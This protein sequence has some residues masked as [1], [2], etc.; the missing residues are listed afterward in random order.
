[1]KRRPLPSL[2]ALRVFE[3]FAHFQN[4]TKAAEEL[5]ISPSAISRHLKILSDQVGTALVKPDGRNLRLTVPG[6]E[7]ASAVGGALDQV[8]DAVEAMRSDPNS[9]TVRA[10]PTFA[11]RW[12]YPRLTRFNSEYPAFSV[13][14]V[15]RWAGVH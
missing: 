7:L 2:N 4:V 10:L 5:N 13:R 9:I 11:I 8:R 15:T 12:L 14:L 3:A 6:T 1:M